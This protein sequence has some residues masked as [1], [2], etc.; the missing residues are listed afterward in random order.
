MIYN[1]ISTRYD[2]SKRILHFKDQNS[3]SVEFTPRQVKAMLGVHTF[4]GVKL[5]SKDRLILDTAKKVSS[6]VFGGITGDDLRLFIDANLRDMVTGGYFTEREFVSDLYQAVTMRAPGKVNVLF[7]IRATGKTVAMCH[8]MR[9]LMNNK[10]SPDAIAYLDCTGTKTVSELEH[11]LKAAQDKGI[12]YVFIDEASAIPN[13]L[14]GL[15]TIANLYASRASLTIAGTDSYVFAEAYSDRLFH[16]H[17]TF[18]L[19]FMNLREYETLSRKSLA[20]ALKDSGAFSNEYAD[21]SRLYNG[22]QTSIV[23][24]IVRTVARNKSYFFKEAKN[25]TEC[26]KVA[27]LFT[28]LN[29]DQLMYLT[30]AVLLDA[31]RHKQEYT[32]SDIGLTVKDP[33]VI[34]AFVNMSG[35]RYSS[36]EDYREL[37][38]SIA[39]TYGKGDVNTLRTCLA[40][41]DVIAVVNNVLRFNGT[42]P[43]AIQV[44]IANAETEVV[45]MV[46]NLFYTLCFLYNR[47]ED[48]GAVFENFVMAHAV[49][50]L[51]DYGLRFEVGFARFVDDSITREIDLVITDNE[52]KVTFLVELK[53]SDKPRGTRHLLAPMTDKLF[54]NARKYVC[55]A[56]ESVE[57]TS[58]VTSIGVRDFIDALFNGLSTL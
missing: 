15:A 45:C 31:T 26:G 58:A 57:T 10:I 41:L 23:N 37:V 55:Y 29:D 50:L 18:P 2:G 17:T 51:R 42:D 12:L 38:K 24:N 54:P 14:N 52:R 9:R 13:M 34:R 33:S 47:G 5:D 40:G 21:A 6:P 22:I 32:V 7:G 16:R 35:S 39:R 27:K 44:N 36:N 8:C 20:Y 3:R 30:T 25:L 4:V 28:K 46:Q 19:A 43:G 48:K 56:G 1:Y 11:T 53:S 49:A